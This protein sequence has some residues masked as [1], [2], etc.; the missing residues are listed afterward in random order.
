MERRFEQFPKT[1]P[2]C[3]HCCTFRR[4]YGTVVFDF[5]TYTL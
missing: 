1:V 4:R 3:G 5:L 2:Y